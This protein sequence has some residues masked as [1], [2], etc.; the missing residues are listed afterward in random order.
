MLQ[1]IFIQIPC[2]IQVMFTCCC[3]EHSKNLTSLPQQEF[4][5]S[6]H[7][8][9]VQVSLLPWGVCLQ[10]WFRGSILMGSLSQISSFPAFNMTESLEDKER[11]M[12]KTGCHLGHVCPRLH[13][14]QPN[15]R[16]QPNCKGGWKMQPSCVPK[17]DLGEHL[18][19]FAN[20]FI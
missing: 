7:H 14:L 17:L 16:P 10:S 13:W 2:V 20:V 19:K 15:Q 9:L 6:W 3:N 18:A 4:V 12:T 5:S 1:K 11:F 8:C